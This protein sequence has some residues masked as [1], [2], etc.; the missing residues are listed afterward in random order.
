MRHVATS[1]ESIEPGPVSG[2]PA[3]QNDEDPATTKRAR[4]R[5]ETARLLQQAADVDGEARSALH[6]EAIRLNIQV[7]L[8]IAQRY[9]SRGIDS[10]DLNQVACLGLTKAVRSF[11]PSVG[12]DFLSFAV[13]T[14]RGE[15]R[16]Y[17]RDFGWTIRPPRWLQELQPR[18]VAAEAEL[19]QQLGRSPRPTELAQHLDVELDRVLDALAA[20]GCFSPASLDAPYGEG[21]ASP[22]DRLGVVEAA[23]GTV[24][25]RAALKPLLASLT[26]RERRILELRFGAGLTQAEIGAEIGVTQMQISRLLTRL[27][28]KMRKKLETDAA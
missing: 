3:V 11:D 4:R 21:E 1:H 20:N 5:Q 8:E 22:A 27:L 15:I 6:D 13:P 7:A 12:T 2:A 24:E 16:R 10:D 18:L 25:A 17:F 9:H 26:D 23:F 14:I 28:A 19:F